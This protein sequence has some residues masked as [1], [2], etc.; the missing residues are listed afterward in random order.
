MRFEKGIKVSKCVSKDE[1]RPRLSY[2]AYLR[3]RLLQ[4]TD[5]HVCTSVQVDDTDND[6]DGYIPLAALVAAEKM[7]DP[8]IDASDPECVIV[9][10]VRYPRTTTDLGAN[11]FPEL[12]PIIQTVE[13]RKPEKSASVGINPWYLV[14]VAKSLG[15][16]KRKAGVEITIDPQDHLAPIRVIMTTRHADDASVAVVVPIRL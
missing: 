1:T 8:H 14:K 16:S 15:V 11:D 9:Q 2:G 4:A 13:N 7:R 12:A 3:G 6:V 5:G 10:R